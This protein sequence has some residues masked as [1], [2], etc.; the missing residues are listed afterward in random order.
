MWQL[1]LR[2]QSLAELYNTLDRSPLTFPHVTGNGRNHL[3]ISVASVKYDRLLFRSKRRKNIEIAALFA[4]VFFSTSLEF[5]L[6]TFVNVCVR[7][8]ERES[9][10]S[11]SASVSVCIRFERE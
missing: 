11:V 8:R 10:V 3:S 1:G 5:F 9:I 4:K 6:P 2:S 7:E